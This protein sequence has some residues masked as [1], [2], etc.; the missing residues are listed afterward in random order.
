MSVWP[1]SASARVGRDRSTGRHARRP[2]ASVRV[3]KGG[4]DDARPWRSGIMVDASARGGRSNRSSPA[5]NTV[6]RPSRLAGRPTMSD[7]RRPLE[8]DLPLCFCFLPTAPQW[9]PLWNDVHRGGK[10]PDGAFASYATL[11]GRSL[12]R[13]VDYPDHRVLE[14]AT[15]VRGEFRPHLFYTKRDWD[16][17]FPTLGAW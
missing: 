6:G 17:A 4:A 12:Y 9:V 13:I 15:I 14:R 1:P 8:L 7:P 11:D 10:V 2:S 5:S 3:G 16:S